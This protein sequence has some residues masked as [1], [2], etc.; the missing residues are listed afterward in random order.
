M[1]EAIDDELHREYDREVPSTVIG[2]RVMAKLR[3]L[4]QVAY[5]RFASEYQQF[6]SVD[7]LMEELHALRQM[8]KDVR[9]QQSL[10][11]DGEAR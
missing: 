10:F 9:N 8:P 11:R 3:D 6:K 5:I 2:D 4:D 1:V 7:D